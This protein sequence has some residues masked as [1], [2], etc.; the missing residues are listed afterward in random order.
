MR[1]ILRSCIRVRRQM[2]NPLGQAARASSGWPT[3]T[4]CHPGIAA[5]LAALTA[6]AWIDAGEPVVLL[7]DSGTGKTI[8]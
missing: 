5:T 1:D 8:S 3:S 7:G 6:G 2:H 4:R